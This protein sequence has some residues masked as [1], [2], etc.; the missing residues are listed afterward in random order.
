MTR[1]LFNKSQ[2]SERVQQTRLRLR[3]LAQAQD[4][5]IAELQ[6]RTGLTRSLIERYW[7]NTT[8]TINLMA[9]GLLAEALQV[10]VNDLIT[11]EPEDAE[12]H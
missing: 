1:V 10:S 12:G 8:K 9:L 7:R 2:V 11:W 6:R 4:V 3:E 5:T